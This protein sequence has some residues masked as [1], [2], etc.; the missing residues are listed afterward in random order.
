[1]LEWFVDGFDV[2]VVEVLFNNVDGDIFGGIEVIVDCCDIF[3]VVV[4]VE[5]FSGFLIFLGMG[6]CSGE[7]KFFLV[8]G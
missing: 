1:M 5:L 8:N 6:Y 7:I 3:F 4:F 2:L